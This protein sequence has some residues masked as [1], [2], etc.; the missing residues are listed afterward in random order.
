MKYNVHVFKEY[1]VKFEG[2]EA[3][4][5]EAAA[6]IANNM[7]DKRA[8]EIEDTEGAGLGYIVD[9]HGD[10]DYLNSISLNANFEKAPAM[11]ETQQALIDLSAHDGG[12]NY[13]RRRLV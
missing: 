11:N 9:E 7:E 3:E 6:K 2:I 5:P 1:R 8:I 13:K 10:H 12:A 4:S